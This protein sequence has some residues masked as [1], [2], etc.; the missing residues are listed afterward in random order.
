MMYCG[1]LA[2]NASGGDEDHPDLTRIATVMNEAG[3]PSADL[4]LLMPTAVTYDEYID[5]IM[6]LTADQVDRLLE[7][8]DAAH[9]SQ[10]WS[11]DEPFAV[12]IILTSSSIEDEITVDDVFDLVPDDTSPADFAR[13]CVQMGA[14]MRARMLAHLG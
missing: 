2:T 6:S 14:T 10:L 3:L 7:D 12:Q 13:A 4:I 9:G 1:A 8:R 5:Y 11:G